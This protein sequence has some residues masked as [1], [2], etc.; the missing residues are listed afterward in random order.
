MYFLIFFTI[1][2]CRP[3][4][5]KTDGVSMQMTQRRLPGESFDE[6]EARY[7]KGLDE[8]S[9][10]AYSSNLSV[11][12]S[13]VAVDK[14]DEDQVGEFGDITLLQTAFARLR[15][16]QFIE[17]V[18]HPEFR[19]RSTWLYPDDG[20]FARADLAVQNLANW[21]YPGVGKV[22]VF[23]EL[24]VETENSP[25]GEVSWWFHV[26]PV[27]KIKDQLYVLDPAVE[28]AEPLELADWLGRISPDSA[29]LLVNLCQPTAYSPYSRCGTAGEAD[30][31]RSINDQQKYLDPEWDRLV[32][33]GRSPAEELGD[34]PPWLELRQE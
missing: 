13:A 23:G 24:T 6:A 30:L 27:T 22:F 5:V 1:L 8:L 9:L 19:R 34:H 21:N 26:A 33:L 11:K 31:D 3:D 32:E 20:C 16:Y 28:P 17:S 10:D 18:T 12:N 15:D 2:G 7:R 4:P 14:L 25:T 29:E